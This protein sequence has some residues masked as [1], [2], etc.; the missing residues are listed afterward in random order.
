MTAEAL[1]AAFTQACGVPPC[2]YE[3]WA[4]GGAPDLLAGLVVRG[5]KTA[6]ASAGPLYAL[7]NEPLPQ[8]GEYSVILNA[9]DEAV[10]IIRTTRVYTCPFHAVSPEHAYKEG[11]GDKSLAYWRAVHAEFFT[12]CMAEAGLRFT[13]D[14]PVVCEEFE[15]V[16]APQPPAA[17]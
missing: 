1:W 3:A 7:E 16:Y 14:M 8:V 17:Q 9:Q 10:C 6:T 5:E 12:A 13:P 4:F 15:L 11:E 2:E